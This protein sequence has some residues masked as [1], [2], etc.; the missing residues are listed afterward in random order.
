MWG[1]RQ[2]TGGH[3]HG[4][5]MGQ[6]TQRA[7]DRT[8]GHGMPLHRDMEST[9]GRRGCQ[10]HT[11][12]W[13]R[14]PQERSQGRHVAGDEDPGGPLGMQVEQWCG[15]TAPHSLEQD[16]DPLQRGR[17]AVHF[18]LVQGR[19]LGRARGWGHPTQG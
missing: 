4:E 9:W 1:R 8:P 12:Q 17:H 15:P 6:G 5:Q 3:G 10:G 18:L 11:G 19:G 7:R 14:M 13:D 16:G 2:D